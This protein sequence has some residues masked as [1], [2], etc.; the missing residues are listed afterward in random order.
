M[1]NQ[2]IVF[3]EILPMHKWII[4][5]YL[6]IKHEVCFMRLNRASKDKK[7]VKNLV[8]NG[9]LKKLNFD[10]KL[11]T[12][13]GIYYD[14]AFD[15]IDNFFKNVKENR[16][17]AKCLK[18]YSNENI[19]LLFK[20]VLHRKLARFYYLNH[21]LNQIKIKYSGKRI[22]FIPYFEEK[23]IYSTDCCEIYDYF[24]FSKQAKQ[25]GAHYSETDP[26][27]FPMWAIMLS[28]VNAGKRRL[29]IILK[30]LGCFFWILLLAVRYLVKHSRYKKSFYKY[31]IMVINP[32]RQ[33]TNKIQKIDFLIDNKTIKKEE[34]IF[35]SCK[36]LEEK[37]ILYLKNNGLNYLDDVDRFISG[38]EIRKI[39]PIY[40][41]LL[42]NF[43]KIDSLVLDTGLKAIYFYLRWKSLAKNIE[44]K[45][46][47]SFCDMGQQSVARNIILEQGGCKTYYYMDTGNF[48]CCFAKEGLT[49]QYRGN[50]FG[51]L[52]YTY[53]IAWNDIS[54]QYFKGLQ[55][56][57]EN[58]LNLGCFWAEHLK[59]IEEGKIASDFREKLHSFGYRKTMKLIS[60]FDS[61]LNDNFVATYED[62]I[63]FLEGILKL[64]ND[65]PN[66]FIVLKEKMPRN[67]HKKLSDRYFDIVNLY[68]R[69]ENHA[70]CYCIKD[71]W[72]SA[73][74]VMAFSDLTISFP[75]SA[76][77]FEA[78]SAGKKA[79]WYDA[80][81]KFRDVFYDKIHGLVYHDYPS[82]LNRVKELLHDTSN[83]KYS[84]YIDKTIKVK[85]ENYIDGK[86]ISRF[87]Q[88]LVTLKK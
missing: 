6:F 20:K 30:L 57:I 62:G 52:Y 54:S 42:V 14:L 69:L 2:K 78:L 1:N 16:I 7:W 81:N 67:Y 13:E 34:V 82:L 37:N 28:Y 23:I 55:C 19:L 38:E 8:N 4:T 25:I 84:E 31:A 63:K 40:F 64:L 87:R 68:N 9:K 46:L 47:I 5:W 12:Y 86:A 26:A 74:E 48:S 77:T 10:L 56:N 70:Q 61:S 45:N 72:K 17:I 83:E 22:I 44:I 18:L 39:L 53:F 85:L 50:A 35:L 79:I 27:K 75:F 88:Q 60:V 11:H 33:F 71:S 43:L 21:A 73:S 76:T 58:Y 49:N 59:L 29:S 41:L 36:K 3:E 15:N 32:S 24:K 51:F 66:V 80:T 65:L